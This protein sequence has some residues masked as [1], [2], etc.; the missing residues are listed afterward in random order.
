[1]NLFAFASVKGIKL[2]KRGKGNIPQFYRREDLKVA[3]N[4]AK[5]GGL[6]DFY[7]LKEMIPYL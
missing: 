7:S 6:V 4:D 3:K 1:M 5:V 2:K